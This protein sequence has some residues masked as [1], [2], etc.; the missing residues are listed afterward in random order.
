MGKYARLT[1]APVSWSHR[2]TYSVSLLVKVANPHR[3]AFE[4]IHLAA[5][6][7]CLELPSLSRNLASLTEAHNSPLWLRAEARSLTQLRRFLSPAPPVTG[8]LY[9]PNSRIG[10]PATLFW[11][12]LVILGIASAPSPPPQRKPPLNISISRFLDK[13]VGNPSIVV[14]FLVEELL[15]GRLEDFVHIYTD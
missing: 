6:Y 10:R 9:Q 2:I 3:E 14:R 4:V 13:K 1:L 11:E 8:L 12:Q 15:D 7:V 5:L